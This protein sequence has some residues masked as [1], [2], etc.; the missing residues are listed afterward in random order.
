MN[1]L[2]SKIV[3]AVTAAAMTLFVSSGSLQTFVNEIDAHAA[4]TDLILGDVD[5]D[6]KVNVFDLGL[7]KRELL[8]P[9]TTS[10][11]MAAADV[12]AD[13]VVD[14]KDV[15]EVQ[16]FLLVERDTFTGSTRKNIEPPDTSIVTT[17]Q[18]VETSL[19]A[20]MADKTKELGN[21]VNVYN[22]LYNNMRSEFYYG[23]R[24]GAIGTFEQGGG[25]DADLSSLLIAMLRYLGY[26]AN[27]VTDIVGFSADQLMKWTN[28]NSIEAATKIY[29]CQGR[30]N[31]T[32]EHEG[33]TYYFCDYTYVQV[34]DAGSTYYLD[35]CFKEYETQ[36][37]SIQTLVSGT[38]TSDIERILQKTD[39][40]YLDSISDT[41]FNKALTDLEGQN[42]TF[43]SKKPIQKNVTKLPTTSPHLFNIEPTVITALDN[44]RSDIIEIGFNNSNKKTYHAS[45]LYKKSVTVE[46]V[47][48]DDTLE[49]HEW[50]DFD[51][52]SIFNLPPYALGQALSVA[53]VIKVDGKAVLTGPAI[54]FE[55]KQTLY[56][57]SKTGGKVETF[58]EELSP[59]EL[60]CIVFG[61]GTISPNE[62]SEVYSKSADQTASANQKYQLSEKTDASKVN[63]KNVYNADYLGS[64]LRLT[65]VMYFSQLDIYTQTL[66]ENNNVNCEDTVKIGVFGFKPSVYPSKV[67]VAGEPYGI[68]K[69]GQF[70]VDIVSNSVST[71]S[72][73]SD[74][75]QL[76]AFNMER[77]YISSELESA[78]L[79]QIVGVESLS[80]V[81]LFKHAQ[82]KGINIVSLSKNTTKKVSDLKISDED[83]KRLQAEIDAGNTIISMEQSIT[84]GDWT[85]IGYIVETA[86]QSAQTFMISGN[87]NGGVCSS[88]VSVAAIIG[89]AID[90]IWLVE[91]VGLLIA[92]LSAMTSLA[93]MPV[94]TVVLCVIAIEFM[95]FDII[96]TIANNYDYYMNDNEEAGRQVK[97]NAAINV[98]TFGVTKI[99]G[100]IISQAKNASNCAKYGKNVINGLKSSGFTTAEVNAQISKFS[101]L[102][103][104]Q[105]TIQT[106]LNNPKCMFLGDDVLKVIGE[107]GGSQRLLAEFVLRNSDDVA[108]GVVNLANKEG[109]IG[110]VNLFDEFGKAS[111]N[112]AKYGVT[113]STII[114]K[115]QVDYVLA[116]SSSKIITEPVST[117]ST[118]LRGIAGTPDPN[119]PRPIERQNEA[120][121]LFADKGFDVEMLLDSPNGNGYGLL[122]DSCP[123]YLINGQAF[124]CYSPDKNTSVRNIWST[125]K[126]KTE[127]QARRIVINF[128]D[129]NKTLT[130]LIKQFHTWD[131]STLDE[132]FV[133]KDGEIIRVILK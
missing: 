34:V 78:I 108:K 125:V 54:T 20:Q 18:P 7:M 58:E 113:D 24:K 5:G 77:G 29:A 84:V 130:E 100:A 39:L 117:S 86:D 44:D 101:K 94:V 22:Y 17:N 71:V 56:I 88:S 90:E 85:G 33:V 28:T 92:T 91:T 30:E 15:I 61:V 115:L 31:T 19:T 35:V 37:N 114:N 79:E 102:G 65:G 70:L 89:I 103:C 13:G 76:R 111:Q 127:T 59:G 105:S 110:I 16:Q 62:L 104:S 74:S 126:G 81:Q 109:I 73:V 106:L 83:A 41:A 52:S 2:F 46:Y 98:I 49:Q 57:N 120:A 4:E 123:D 43:F 21:A 107:T 26:D 60:C 6:E 10:I 36:K 12:N 47:V 3:S 68:E 124:D 80:T 118:T 23:S 45:E 11:N 82:E 121:Q 128:D 53:P 66:A 25:N 122:D 63:E 75:A 96:E 129:S 97:I 64:I 132:L 40:N 72:E 50:L 42:Y 8:N 51:A 9:G 32:Y 67:Q 131:I 69:N 27:Y 119:D 112:L 1:I 116:K 99:G 133:I 95:V 48:S 87:M 93:F 55:E 38:S 14:V